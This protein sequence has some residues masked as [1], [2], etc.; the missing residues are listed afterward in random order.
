[1]TTTENSRADALTDMQQSALEYA[2][3]ICDDHGAGLYVDALR[4]ILAAS[5][6]EQPAAAPMP[7]IPTDAML[8]AARD[9][10]VKYIGAGIGNAAATG[11]WQAMY[12]AVA[13]EPAPAP[14][15]A[16]ERAAFEAWWTRDVPAEHKA[17]AYALLKQFGND[18]AANKCCAEAWEVWRARAASANETGAEGT[19]KDRRALIEMIDNNVESLGNVAIAADEKAL[20]GLSKLLRKVIDTLSQS[21]AQL[22]RSPAMVAEAPAI[23]AGYALVPI[24]PTPEILTA[25]WQN[26]RDS[27]RAWERAIAT[28]Q[29]PA[30]ADARVGLTDEQIQTLW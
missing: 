25:I 22:S 5:P 29:Q 2:I 28:V 26:E 13:V 7:R 8:D 11:C 12:D 4:A 18:Y 6:V 17:S 3:S 23:P 21:R 19:P 27:R 20:A 14:S 15:P 1:M 10:S 24:E 9:W 16:D 30:Q